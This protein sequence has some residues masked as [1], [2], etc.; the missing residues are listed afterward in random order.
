MPVPRTHLPAR[1][2]TIQRA[3]GW[4]DGCTWAPAT[5]V[6]ERGSGRLEEV[7]MG[8]RLKTLGFASLLTLLAALPVARSADAASVSRQCRRACRDEIA[9]CV[10]AG[11]H[12][13]ACRKSVLGS[14]KREGV[15]ACGVG[16]LNHARHPKSTT[17]T[18]TTTTTQPPITTTT[19]GA[20]ATT[21]TT[22]LAGGGAP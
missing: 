19:T 16:G 10:G 2:R 17:T 20:S 8:Q 14:C 6:P 4:F 21:T 1:P 3:C 9:A 22:T 15:A 11:G 18:T 12:P 5:D 13:R 7:E